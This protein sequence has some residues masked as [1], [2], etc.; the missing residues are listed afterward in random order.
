MFMF[1][2]FIFIAF[3]VSCQSQINDSHQQKKKIQIKKIA[4]TSQEWLD[5]ARFDGKQ[6]SKISFEQGIT[7]WLTH[8]HQ[9]DA[10]PLC[11]GVLDSNSDGKE[12]VFVGYGSSRSYRNKKAQIWQYTDEGAT[13]VWTGSE[14][15]MIS[16]MHGT[17][18]GLYVVVSNDKQEMEG[19]FLDIVSKTLNIK[20]TQKLAL[21]Q[22]PLDKERIL[23]GR[24][25]GD[26]PKS[27][28]DL[29]Y[30]DSKEQIP[31]KRGIRALQMADLNSDGH[32]DLL[33]SDGWH[34]QY[35]TNA[36]ARIVLYEG[37]DFQQYRTIGN[38]DE[39]YSINRIDVSD[40]K[41]F[42]LAIGS[43]F[44]YILFLDELG[45]KS[46]QIAEIGERGTMRFLHS[47]DDLQVVVSGNKG[48][49]FQI[50]NVNP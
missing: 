17:E 25:Y 22:Y 48:G 43:K 11:S 46:I 36:Q 9:I 1:A 10:Q 33:V 20:H 7:N 42:L 12:E 37:P 32:L 14:N 19:G 39:D 27:D 40:D 28:G 41:M 50:S 2:K 23:V 26:V 44:G 6:D 31:T 3:V 45:W 21:R 16:D 49:V 34:F 4:S 24:V 30:S 35:G 38:F 29:R 15:A 47:Q 13:L 8:T 18:H 5:V